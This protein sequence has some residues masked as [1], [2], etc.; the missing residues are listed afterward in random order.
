[1]RLLG[2]LIPKFR[3]DQGQGSVE[4]VLVVLVAA[5]MAWSLIS[6]I[7]GDGPR[8]LWNTLGGLL[9]GLIGLFI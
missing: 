8:G 6:W 9:T 4:Y 5:A 3:K 7:K 2:G 1:M